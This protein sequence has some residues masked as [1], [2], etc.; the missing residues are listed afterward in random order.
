MR[1]APRRSSDPVSATRPQDAQAHP[2]KTTAFFSMLFG[3]G[4]FLLT[5]ALLR[6]LGSALATLAERLGG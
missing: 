3:L 1:Q 6:W 2:R 5:L 4:A